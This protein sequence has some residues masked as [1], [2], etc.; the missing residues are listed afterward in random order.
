MVCQLSIT[1]VLTLSVSGLPF[2]GADV[3]GF[4]GNRAPELLAR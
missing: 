4:F 1:M 3:G 2:C